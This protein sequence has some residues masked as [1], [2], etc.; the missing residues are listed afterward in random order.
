[1][2][3]FPET[4]TV[5]PAFTASGYVDSRAVVSDYRHSSCVFLSNFNTYFLFS[6]YSL[7]TFFYSTD[8]CFLWFLW[9]KGE[10]FY[11][12]N[13]VIWSSTHLNQICK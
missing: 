4:I 5:D 6:Q 13:R 10:K 8:I 11:M 3:E 7:C 2:S 1:M 9:L 12:K